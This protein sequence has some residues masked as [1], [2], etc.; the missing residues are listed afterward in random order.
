[1]M[2]TLYTIKPKLYVSRKI[3]NLALAILRIT[4][5]NTWYMLYHTVFLRP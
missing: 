5:N 1:M 4:L 3:A 2:Y